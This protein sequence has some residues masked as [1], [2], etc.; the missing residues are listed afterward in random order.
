MKIKIED[1]KEDLKKYNWKLLSDKYENLDSE[2]IFECSE[3]HKVYSSWKKIRNNKIC[4]ICKENNYKDPNSLIIKKASKEKRVLALDQ[5]THISGWSVFDNGKLIKY[6]I[7]ESTADS[8]VQRLFDIKNWLIN[9][10]NNWKPDLVAIEGIQFQNNLGDIKVGITTFE[11]LARLQGVLMITCHE[12]K[13]PFEICHTQTWRS[14]CNV[15]GRTKADKKRSAQ[16]IVKNMYDIS[17]TNDMADAILI[18][19]YSSENLFK[20]TEIVNWE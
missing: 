15:K 9:M 16:L 4:P 8:Q 6:G 7:F 11:S 17:V 5:A 13:I 10:V 2:L 3:G 12:L 18:G 20:K 14:Y 1:I 19:K